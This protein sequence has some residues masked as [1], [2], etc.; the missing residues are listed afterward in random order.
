MIEPETLSV[1]YNSMRFDDEVTRNLFWRNLYDAY[2]REWANGCSRWDLFPFVLAVWP[3][4]PKA[5]NGL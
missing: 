3:S 1:G 5:L 2:E 4:G